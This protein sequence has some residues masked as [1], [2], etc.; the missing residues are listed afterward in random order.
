VAKTFS[1]SGRPP[2]PPGTPGELREQIT[3]DVREP[4]DPGASDLGVRLDLPPLNKEPPNRLVVLGDSI[5][6]GFKS[7]AIADTDRSWPALVARYAG[8]GDFRFPAFPGPA[9]CPGLPL[10]LEAVARHFQE[11][12]PG[13]VLD[14]VADAFLLRRLR[15]VMDEVEDYWEGRDGADAIAGVAARPHHNLASWGWDLRDALSRDIGSLRERVESAEGRGDAV[16]K[17]LP[18]A[19]WERSALVTLAG[20]DDR[21][22]PVSLARRLGEEGDEEG[23]GIETLVVALG[24]NNVL[25]TVLDFEVRWTDPET[26][27]FRDVDAKR[28]R[29]AWLPSHFAS[30]FDAL[31]DEVAGIRARHVIFVTVPHVTIAPMV[32]GVRNKMPGDRYFARYTRAWLTDQVFN[33]NRHPCLTGD[34]LRVLDFAVDRYNDHIARRVREARTAQGGGRDWRLLDVAGVLD[35]LAYRRYLVDD[36]ARPDWWTP[37]VLP[38]A[39]RELSPQPDTRFYRADARGRYEGGLFSLDGVHP[40]TIGYAVLAGE[41]M[42]VMKD[43]G[44]RLE[45]D[46]PDFDQVVQEDDTLISSPPTRIADILEL[47]E[48]VDR[49]SGLLH[50]VGARSA[51]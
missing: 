15:E 27:D 23:P 42:R 1:R 8:I 18:S 26:Q 33:A 6:H 49:T 20:G 37:Y 5:S 35:R 41:V 17:Q 40:S 43:C 12:A 44:V 36:E 51:V 25:G 24:A 38:D 45:R 13:S 32:R 46:A 4:C 9:S 47:V 3:W 22:T 10:N 21:D 14:V 30:E 11:E 28:G 2:V 16:F 31:V 50:A 7:F 48:W 34:D 39:Y 29:N 19:A